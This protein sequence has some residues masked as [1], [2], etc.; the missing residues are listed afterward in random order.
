MWPKRLLP[1][2][3]RDQLEI[4]DAHH[5]ITEYD[6]DPAGEEEIAAWALSRNALS[7]GSGSWILPFLTKA[8]SVVPILTGLILK[9]KRVIDA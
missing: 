4:H 9:P 1:N 3:L 2:S 7:F 5:L 8:D 6:T